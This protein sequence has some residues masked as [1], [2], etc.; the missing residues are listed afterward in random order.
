MFFVKANE[1]ILLEEDG[2]VRMMKYEGLLVLIPGS[3][4][5]SVLKHVRGSTIT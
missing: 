3:M 1:N 5:K 2:I 4:A